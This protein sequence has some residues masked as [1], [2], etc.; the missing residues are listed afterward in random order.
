MWATSRLGIVTPVAVI[1]PVYLS[2]ANITNITLHNASHVI[3]YDLKAGDKIEIIRSGEV[4]PKF[5]RVVKSAEGKYVLP[6]KM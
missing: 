2:G 1:E 4:I 6:E 3:A 5:L